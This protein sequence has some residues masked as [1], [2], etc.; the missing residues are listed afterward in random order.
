MKL[1]KGVTDKKRNSAEYKIA[2][3]INNQSE[4]D[5]KTIKYETQLWGTFISSIKPNIN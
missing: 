4:N 2:S 1:L 3:I 5:T